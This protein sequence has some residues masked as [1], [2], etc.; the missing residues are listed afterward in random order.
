MDRRKEFIEAVGSAVE[1]MGLNGVAFDDAIP[2][3]Q[4]DVWAVHF[5]EGSDR[6]FKI[7]IDLTEVLRDSGPITPETL[8]AEIIKKLNA[9]DP[10][11]YL[12]S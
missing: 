5:R 8:K 6:Y 3:S 1:E 11:D 2:R 10:S 9:R 12:P 7:D 4:S